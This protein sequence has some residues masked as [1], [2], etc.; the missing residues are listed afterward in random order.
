LARTNKFKRFEEISLDKLIVGSSNIRTENVEESI[1][2]LAE[3]IYV[4]G[5]LE[6][7]VVF[8]IN[9]LTP[10][11]DL[12]EARKEFKGKYEILAGQRRYNAFVK[13]NK[14]YPGEGFDK[15]PCHV[16]VP[17]ENT[18]EAKAISI[19]ENLTQLPMTLADAIDA[20]DFLY[21][22]YNDERI[23]AKKHGISV[24]LVKKYVK[25]ARLPKLLQDNLAAFHKSPKTAMNI[26][27]EAVDALDY[28]KDGDV[29]EDKV[30]EFAKMLGKKREKSVE[31]YKKLKQAGELNPKKSL[32]D[33]E[34]ESNKIRNPRRYN[35]LLE[36]EHADSLEGAAKQSGSTPEDEAHDIIVDGL[37]T[38]IAKKSIP[39]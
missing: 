38:R 16:R 1:D 31:E 11:H 32:D 13:L 10:E 37:K 21:K 19:G 12:Y 20:C 35:V 25:F 39:D 2:D 5:L 9:D 4:N 22:K 24:A 28:T 26:A 14:S 7:I 3:H 33:I 17:P 15:I 18:Q 23:I 8:E 27:L 6:V 36:A 34:K 30:Y 29:P